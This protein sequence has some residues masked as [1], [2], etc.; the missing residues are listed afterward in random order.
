ME[1][2]FLLG[3]VLLGG[4]FIM[5][6]YNHFKN[7][8]ALSGYAASKGTPNPKLAVLGTG[9]LLLLGGAG[10][11]LGVYIQ[12]AVILLSIFLVGVTFQMHKYWTV[13]EP[14]QRMGEHVNFYKNLALLGAVL[15]L[16]FIPEPWE[17]SLF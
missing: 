9:V 5:N 11:L 4:Y 12:Y 10:I 2:L 13:A 16:L 3:R 17:M 7:A 1:Y 15:L 8:N 6:A 14:M